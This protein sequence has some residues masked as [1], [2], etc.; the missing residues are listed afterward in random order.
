MLSYYISLYYIVRERNPGIKF[1]PEDH[2]AEVVKLEKDFHKKIASRYPEWDSEENRN[3]LR[4]E[5]D[6]LTGVISKQ[7]AQE[8]KKQTLKGLKEKFDNRKA[9]RGMVT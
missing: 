2:M 7:K 3:A 4:G 8:Q 9:L 6:F 5:I 1:K